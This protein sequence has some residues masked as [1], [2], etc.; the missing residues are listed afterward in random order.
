MTDFLERKK[1]S[2]FDAVVSGELSRGIFVD[3]TVDGRLVVYSENIHFAA[4]PSLPRTEVK[5]VWVTHPN[6]LQERKASH[7][8]WF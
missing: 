8:A 6:E 2:S 7:P 1:D 4:P 5:S 3:S